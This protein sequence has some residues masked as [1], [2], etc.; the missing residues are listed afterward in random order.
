MSIIDTSRF[1]F[2]FHW[3][4]PG[5]RAWYRRGAARKLRGAAVL[6][7]IFLTLFAACGFA[8]NE[9]TQAPPASLEATNTLETLRTYL[10]LQEQI[11]ATQLAI[12]ENRRESQVA[13]SR[14]A[15]VFAGRLQAI[16]QALTLQRSRELEAMQ[17]SN[18]LMLIVAGSIA[19]LGFVAMLLMAYLHWR[20]M[21]RL[22]EVAA[23]MPAARGF[24]ALAPVGAL[25]QGESTVLTISPA[26]Q[27]N[28]RL[29]GAIDRLEQRIHELEHSAQAGFRYRQARKRE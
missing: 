15:E 7:F 6:V 24:N 13:A 28:A 18:K 12:E 9:S 27:S 14:H 16:E 8:Q 1:H 17:G 21:H 22:A 25:G 4:C 2:Q 11:H 19:A 29:L 3:P 20:S 26:E 10:Q 5:G 23:S